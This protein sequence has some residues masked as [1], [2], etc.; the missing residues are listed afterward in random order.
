MP[1]LCSLPLG[2]HTKLT[3]YGGIKTKDPK[4][5]RIPTGKLIYLIIKRPN[6]TFVVQLINQFVQNVAKE[7]L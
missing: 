7:H 3:N 1:N 4:L 2:S 6:I 5:Y